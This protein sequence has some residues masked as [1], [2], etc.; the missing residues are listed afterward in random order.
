MLLMKESVFIV[1]EKNNTAL[2]YL[3]LNYRQALK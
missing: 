2:I 3:L 1:E